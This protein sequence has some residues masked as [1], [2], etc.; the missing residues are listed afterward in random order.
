MTRLFNSGFTIV[1]LILDYE[2]LGAK[3][4]PV[5]HK[6][7]LNPFK[8]AGR[9]TTILTQQSK[10][11]TLPEIASSAAATPSQYSTESSSKDAL[12][13]GALCMTLKWVAK[14]R[15]KSLP[16]SEISYLNFVNL[17]FKLGSINSN[18]IKLFRFVYMI[19]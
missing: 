12:G 2:H 5:T 17:L 9:R 16:P 11:S 15:N 8:S 3:V 19:I 14:N 1:F 10:K 4:P 7:S 6:K 13:I 18:I